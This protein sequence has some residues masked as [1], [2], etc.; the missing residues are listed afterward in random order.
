MNT[1]QK[2]CARFVKEGEFKKA[3]P[4][5]MNIPKWNGSVDEKLKPLYP[6]RNETLKEE[7]TIHEL[8]E[9]DQWMWYKAI[10]NSKRATSP[11][12]SG[13]CMDHYIQCNVKP[14]GNED[15]KLEIRDPWFHRRKLSVLQAA[16]Q[17][18]R[19]GS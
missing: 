1:R 13:K 12:A 14:S 15:D 11:A 7:S 9:I 19:G 3:R 6:E 8:P 16:G 5:L 10:K 18:D 17:F 4:A 2:R